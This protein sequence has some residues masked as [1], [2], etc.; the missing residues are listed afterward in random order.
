MG[1]IGGRNAMKCGVVG[2]AVNLASR[3]EGLTRVTGSKLLISET[4]E[5]RLAKDHPFHLRRAGRVRV[6]G[7]AAV[8]RTRRPTGS[9]PSARA[10]GPA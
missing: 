2:D 10:I 4:T 6:R 9:E 7:R 3:I 8:V 1:L 5:A